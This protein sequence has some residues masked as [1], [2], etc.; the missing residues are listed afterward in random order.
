MKRKLRV[1]LAVGLVIPA[2]FL[3]GCL[4]NIFQ[5]AMTVGKGNASV[6]LGSGLL[7]FD[8]EGNPSWSA[9]PQA[10]VT[11]GLS[12]NIDFGLQSGAMIPLSTGDPG[13]L[14]AKGDFKFL[15]TGRKSPVKVA[16]GFG[17]GYGIEFL[18][19][20]AFG[21]LFVDL[22]P[23]AVAYQPTLTIADNVALW[24]H[25]AGGLRLNLSPKA[26][27]LVMADYRGPATPGL[28]SFLIA[29]EIGF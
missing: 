19:W 29:L 20:G 21:E 22:G 15:V 9:T 16:F 28:I 5:T 24:H 4:F 18:G 3:S 6:T 23:F 10:R 25:I 14:G 12:D 1:I 27:I 11:F 26:S 2:L 7:Y 8:F 13:W 17:G